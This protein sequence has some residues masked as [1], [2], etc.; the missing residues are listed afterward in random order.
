MGMP[1]TVEIAD[2]AACGDHLE[3]VFAY[4]K[5]VEDTFSPYAATSETSRINRGL[6]GPDDHSDDMQTIMRLAEKTRVE[7]DGYFDV[8]RDGS[9]NPVGL[10]KGWAINN[11]ADMLR[12]HGRWDFYI[13]AGG[14]VQV[15]GLNE[16]G[17]YWAVGIRNPFHPGE[18]VKVL[19]L[20]DIGIA[21]SGTY[22][23]GDH[24]YDPHSLEE[25]PI[26]DVVSLTV[27]G[28]NV[29]EADRYATAAFAM[30]RPGL[31]FIEEMPGF[32]A[33]LID[34]DGIATMTSGFGDHTIPRPLGRAR[35]V[36]P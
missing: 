35:G 32:E 1:V 25:G 17:R 30:G 9:F 22:V 28:P 10:V 26:G 34:K 13:E 18:I 12:R 20:S 6:L 5:Y 4:F 2:E 36:T 15:S 7:T 19:Y 31:D 3:E 24:I 14:D 23:R 21:T 33:Y 11:A 16:A 8:Y 29:Y 27:V